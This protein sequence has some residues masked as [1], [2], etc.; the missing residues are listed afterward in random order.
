M[1][2]I[3]WQRISFL[4]EK[5]ETEISD[6]EFLL[7]KTQIEKNPPRLNK[8]KF[9]DFLKT[10]WGL[11]DHKGLVNSIKVLKKDNNKI[12]FQYE[13]PKKTTTTIPKAGNCNIITQWKQFTSNKREVLL[14]ILIQEIHGNGTD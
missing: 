12:L 1:M 6:D 4:K 13:K 2:T 7:I 8:I 11:Y 10:M 9:Q 3:S 5:L 14:N